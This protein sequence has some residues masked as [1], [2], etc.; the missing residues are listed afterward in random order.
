MEG[1]EWIT[2]TDYEQGA[3]ETQEQVDMV[4]SDEKLSTLYGGEREFK[5]SF[6]KDGEG[7]GE[8]IW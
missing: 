6:N 3:L 5:H 7:Q 1:T 4:D 2:W 8:R